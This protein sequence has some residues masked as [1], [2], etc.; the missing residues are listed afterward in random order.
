VSSK[1]HQ[2]TVADRLLGRIKNNK[3]ASAAIA[4]G[5]I[6]IGLATFTDAILKLEN[7]VGWRPGKLHEKRV[8]LSITR[9]EL[10]DIDP[11]TPVQVIAY[12]NDAPPYQYPSEVS[13]VE[14][15]TVGEGMSG[16]S[17]P[18]PR[19]AEYKIRFELNLKGSG[20]R[21]VNNEPVRTSTLPFSGPYA[22][23]AIAD[24]V[25]TAAISAKIYFSLSD[26]P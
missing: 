5:A 13:G 6:V 12:V 18:I 14:W 11:Q 17:F 23:H 2:L 4:L 25:K 3:L 1:S 8:L 16:Q 7:F 22:V 20:R 24:N 21:L 26:E 9:V 10:F 19:A 15:I